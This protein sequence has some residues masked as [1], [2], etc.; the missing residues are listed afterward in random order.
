M[1]AL[2]LGGAGML[3]HRLWRELD[4]QMDAFATV[5]GS[6]DDYASLDWFDSR[7][8]IGAVD[9]LSDDPVPVVEPRI[10]HDPLAGVDSH[11]G[12]VG[13]QDARLRHG[14]KSFPHP[15]VEM[16]ERRGPHLDQ[17][18]ARPCN[19]VGSVLVAQNFGAAVLVDANCLQ[20]GAH[21]LRAGR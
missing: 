8:V 14:R 13:T 20:G 2:V 10:D 5:R 7:R 1:R 11:A 9:V 6:A 15:E 16:V 17:H 18:L 12:S 19:G 4:Q 3:G 21:Y